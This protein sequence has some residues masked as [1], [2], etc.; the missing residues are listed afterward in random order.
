MYY[1][2]TC[3]WINVCIYI[4]RHTCI[5]IYMHIHEG[6]IYEASWVPCIRLYGLRLLYT[7]HHLQMTYT[8]P[9]TMS[10]LENGLCTVLLR[11]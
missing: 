5:S 8:M 4:L 10:S 9:H 6:Y 7:I 2:Q 1:T 3:V 11:K